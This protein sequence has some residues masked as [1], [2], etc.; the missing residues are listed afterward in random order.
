MN[1]LF[2]WLRIAIMLILLG[3][4]V[5]GVKL[6]DFEEIRYNGSILCVSCIG[7]E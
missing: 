1:A 6:G 7:I 2:K 4:F 5:Y 3:L